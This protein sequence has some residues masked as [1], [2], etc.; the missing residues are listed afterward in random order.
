M[1]SKFAR[2][3]AMPRLACENSNWGM[4]SPLVVDFLYFSF[5][6]VD[7]NWLLNFAES[8]RFDHAIVKLSA[9]FFVPGAGFWGTTLVFQS[10]LALE[11]DLWFSTLVRLSFKNSVSMFLQALL[12]TGAHRTRFSIQ[13]GKTS[14]RPCAINISKCR[15]VET[16]STA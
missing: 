1:A 7:A 16:L 8:L 3:I 5:R 6:E 2:S 13:S 11:C 12:R 4:Y 10:I 15:T 9:L 14:R